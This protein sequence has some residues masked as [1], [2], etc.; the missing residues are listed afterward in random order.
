M[1]GVG[2]VIDREDALVE[3]HRDIGEGWGGI[4][5]EQRSLNGHI[6]GFGDG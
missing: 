6:E 1:K 2:E 3:G 5:S 4:S